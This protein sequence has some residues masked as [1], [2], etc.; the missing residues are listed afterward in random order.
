MDFGLKFGEFP[1]CSCHIYLP[2][3]VLLAKTR[4]N[5]VHLRPLNIIHMS[6]LASAIIEDMLLAIVYTS[7]LP[8]IHRF[9]I[10][11]DV[12]GTTLA[13]VLVF[14][15]VY[16]P[17]MFACLGVLQLLVVFGKKQFLKVKIACGMI[18][19]CFVA[20][21]IISVS[22]L[23]TVY[24][25]NEKPICNNCF[26]PGYR[27]E[28]SF[29][30]VARLSVITTVLSL[31]PSLVAVTVTSLWSCVVFRK[32]H[33]GRDDQ[34]NRRMLSLPFIMPLT[35]LASSILEIALVMLAGW[36]LLSLSLGEHFP[37]WSVFAHLQIV[38]LLRLLFRLIYPLLLT[39]THTSLY[40][41]VKRLLKKLKTRHQI[42]PS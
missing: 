33:T 21:F 16:R 8:S 2:L 39:Y 41:T 40:P 12:I 13:G 30:I 20:S 29:G 28:S 22:S 32:Y 23:R 14:F 17:A 24:E 27:P 26:C 25:S 5:N 35:I 38:A 36:F 42:H 7:Y 31:F 34:L 3:L 37:H 4:N 15:I 18:A 6:L 19:M 11:S 10:C 9:C 1:A